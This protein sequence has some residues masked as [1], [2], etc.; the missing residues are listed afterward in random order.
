MFKKIKL[1][2]AVLLAATSVAN[3]QNYPDR[4]IKIIVPS[5]AGSAPDL[6]TRIVSEKL[7]ASLG[8]PVVVENV[9]GAGGLIAVNKLRTAAADG[10]TLALIQAAVAVVTPF[11]YKQANYDIGR[12][13]E[14][15]GTVA[16]T[17]M[18]FVSNPDFPARTL[19]EAIAAAKAKPEQVSLGSST[20]GS[21]PNLTNEL[22]ASK[23][24]AKFQIVPFSSS[25]QGALATVSGDVNMFTDG[26]APLLPLVKSGRLRALALASDEV[27]PGLEDIPLA[28]DTVPGLNVSGWFVAI[29]PKGT[30]AAVVNR[31]N[32]ALNEALV[33]PDVG[34][35][36]RAFAAYPKTGTPTAARQFIDS[37]KALFGGI[38]GA[39]GIKPE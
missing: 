26:A 21:V 25:S 16:M 36:F 39:I 32:K 14:S 2:A 10:Y 35:K 31:L 19:G 29:A 37:E 22:L 11:T 12:D 8:Q 5:A 23:T 28:K 13:F 30:P 38:I 9:P 24:G 3:A 4:P 7:N 17:P 33:Q 6:I 34:E 20:R 15:I 27:M 1:L 18:L